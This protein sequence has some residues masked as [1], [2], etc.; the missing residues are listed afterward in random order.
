MADI[1]WNF[2]SGNRY[3]SI[4]KWC[5]EYFTVFLAGSRERHSYPKACRKRTLRHTWGLRSCLLHDVQPQRRFFLKSFSAH[6]E[7]GENCILNIILTS[8]MERNKHVDDCF[9]MLAARCLL[10]RLR[11]ILDNLIEKN[12]ADSWRSQRCLPQD[13]PKLHSRLGRSAGCPTLWFDR[14]KA[15]INIIA[16]IRDAA[17]GCLPSVMSVIFKCSWPKPHERLEIATF[18]ATPVPVGSACYAISLILPMSEITFLRTWL[19]LST[20][21]IA[22]SSLPTAIVHDAFYRF[23]RCAVHWPYMGGFENFQITLDHRSNDIWQKCAFF[24]SHLLSNDTNDTG[25]DQTL[26]L[27]NLAHSSTLCSGRSRLPESVAANEIH[28][29]QHHRWLRQK[30]NISAPAFATDQ[31]SE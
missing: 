16:I 4:R 6:S 27:A 3:L 30:P 20:R 5:F 10:G 17:H 8:P 28:R 1:L 19:T 9:R 21:Q 22:A 26:R 25:L 31:S 2:S 11:W 14:T 24:V 18:V 13:C 29:L 23:S 15:I 12:A 7:I